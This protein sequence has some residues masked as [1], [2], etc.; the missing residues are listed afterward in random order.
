MVFI[1]TGAWLA[2]FEKQ[3]QHHRQSIAWWESNAESLLTSDAVI[4]ETLNWLIKKEPNR[5][6]I[7]EAAQDMLGG[8]HNRVEYLTEEDVTMA[9][10][11]FRKYSDQGFSFTDCT[12]LVLM[13]RLG[14]RTIFAF[15][16]AFGRYPGIRRVP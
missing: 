15:D 3:D 4:I 9:L 14:L 11:I 7:A 10:R 6:M 5:S 8:E 2:I 13:K 16:E 1:D 12:N